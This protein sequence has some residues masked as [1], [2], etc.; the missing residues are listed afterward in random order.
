MLSLHE[1]VQKWFS[2]TLFLAFSNILIS[3]REPAILLVKV[4]VAT[5]SR[6]QV[7]TGS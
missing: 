2:G 4:D 7:T 6:V 1:A 5:L 3:F